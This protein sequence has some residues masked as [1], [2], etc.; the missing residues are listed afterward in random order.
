MITR[1]NRSQNPKDHAAFYIGLS[2][3]WAGLLFLLTG[4][5]DGILNGRG[6]HP[7]VWIPA[8]L[9]GAVVLWSILR[10][11]SAMHRVPLFSSRTWA[12]LARAWPP[13]AVALAATGLMFCNDVYNLFRLDFYLPFV[14]LC[15]YGMSLIILSEKAVPE[16][17]DCAWNIFFAGLLYGMAALLWPPL[18]EKAAWYCGIAS[19][20]PHLLTGV[21]L[22]LE[23]N[24]EAPKH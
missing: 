18:L 4:T 3:V 5:A 22:L 13:L 23:L 2:S 10:M 19:G 20:L 16:L 14:W 11:R 17:E 21:K 24:H 1:G 9:P 6:L 12:G 7:G 15:G 8:L